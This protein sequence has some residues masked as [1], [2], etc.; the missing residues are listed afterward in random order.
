MIERLLIRIAGTVQ[1]VGFRPFVYRLARGHG[2]TGEV[3][4]ASTGVV[5]EAQGAREA[6]DGFLRAL[7]SGVPSQARITGIEVASTPV[8]SGETGF[9]ITESNPG[10]TT[11]VNIPP[12]LAACDDCL[13]EVD[14]PAD[15]RH[16]YPFTNCTRCGP[17]FTIV[18]G[19][20]YDRPATTMAEFSFCADCAREY[21]DP[22]DRRFHAQP[23]ACPVC[24]PRLTLFVN[25]A[26]GLCRKPAADPLAETVGALN[27]GKVAAIKGIGGFHLACDAANGEAVARIRRLKSR[28]DKPLAVMCRDLEQVRALC[29]VSAA[30]EAA[31]LDAA[32]PIVILRRLMPAAAPIAAAVAPDQDTLGVMLPYTPLHHLLMA[33]CAGPLVMT[34]ANPGDEPIAASLAELDASVAAGV[35]LVLDHDRRIAARCDDSVAIAGPPAI[36]I[37]RARGYVPKAIPVPA[38]AETLGIGGDQKNTACFV[39]DGAAFFTQ[40]VGDLGAE[41]GTAALTEAMRHLKALYG[42]T[43]RAVGCDMHPAYTSRR[44]ARTLGLPVVEVQHHHAHIAACLAEHLHPGRAIGVAFDG[45]G[46]GPDGTVWGGEFLLADCTGYRRAASLRPVALPG[47]EKAVREPWRMAAAYLYEAFGRSWPDFPGA[48]AIQER[49]SGLLLPLIEHG[50]NAPMSTSAGRLFDAVAALLGLHL[51]C[52]FEGQAAMALETLARRCGSR[53]EPY[54][55]PCGDEDGLIRLD[56]RPVIRRLVE[57]LRRGTDRT[58][59]ALAFHLTLAEGIRAVAFRLRDEH[60]LETAALSGGVFQN[61]LLLSETCTRLEADGFRVLRQHEVPP[62]DGGISLGQAVVASHLLSQGMWS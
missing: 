17:R 50:V 40:H 10:G 4:N 42:F 31:L 37:R 19:L 6:L 49:G 35:D 47:G 41:K 44:L 26:G 58:A 39:R 15:R 29:R 28:A 5:I 57:D 30:E 20:P 61:T 1:G 53:P 48:R 22:A 56:F 34:S 51:A 13:A 32:R 27:S 25:V 38:A 33:S 18:T 16:R 7:E 62:N 21:R 52:T 36:M 46:Y 8:Q 54:L 45:T 60:G 9:A 59:M 11:L 12:D 24:G 55:C 14:D 23:V 3:Y 2:L 43:P